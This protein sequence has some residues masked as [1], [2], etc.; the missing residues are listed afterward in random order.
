MQMSNVDF[1]LFVSVSAKLKNMLAGA[2]SFQQS[3]AAD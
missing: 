2:A 3:Y 1:P